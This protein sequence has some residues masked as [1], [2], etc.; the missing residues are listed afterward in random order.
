MGAMSNRLL[1]VILVG[2]VAA[3]AAYLAHDFRA[4]HPA[5][6]GLKQDFLQGAG[7][8]FGAPVA[9]DFAFP[10][11]TVRRD[12]SSEEIGRLWIQGITPGSRMPGLTDVKFHL[13]AEYRLGMSHRWF[14]GGVDLWV[15]S[16]TVHFGFSEVTIYLSRDYADGSCQLQA[17][18]DHEHL[19]LEAHRKTWEDYQ[20]ILQSA[21]RQASGIP[22]D[23]SRGTYANEAEGR[24]AVEKAISAATDPVFEAFRKADEAAQALIDSR[25]E[26]EGVKEKCGG[27]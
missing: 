6:G 19:H 11:P 14:R 5:S 4:S 7:G 2:L 13:G 1:A 22:T 3:F 17:V 9:Y 27:W 26:Y 12:L 16:L 18:T 20:P 10:T 24:A 21:L 23:S 15:E 8:T 25:A